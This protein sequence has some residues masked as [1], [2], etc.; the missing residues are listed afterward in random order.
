MEKPPIPA[1]IVEPALRLAETFL[2]LA[3][4]KRKKELADAAASDR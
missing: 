2:R 3:E 4:E 1:E